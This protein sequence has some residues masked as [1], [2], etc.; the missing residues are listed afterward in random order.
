MTIT[1]WNE[2][3]VQRAK[4]PNYGDRLF[5]DQ[6]NEEYNR[7]LEPA[8]RSGTLYYDLLKRSIAAL[9]ANTS[10]TA[11]AGNFGRTL[12]YIDGVGGQRVNGWA[13]SAGARIPVNVHLYAG[14]PPGVGTFIGNYSSDY[15]SES[16]VA[17]AC[18]SDG[19]A[20]R[21]SVRLPKS[22]RQ[23]HQGKK[24][25]MYAIHPTGSSPNAALSNN[26]L[27]SVPAP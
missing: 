23:A 17:Q 25:Y 5:T 26:G 9:R 21:F 13:C 3:I 27:F 16:A 15:A 7:D 14:G 19:V 20:Y 24:I 2:W 18:G 10:V 1:G 22:V 12:G 6:Y 11:V 8:A 4:W